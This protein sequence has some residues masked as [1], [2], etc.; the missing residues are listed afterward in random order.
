MQM[1]KVPLLMRTLLLMMICALAACSGDQAGASSASQW[2]AFDQP[3]SPPT[4]TTD[5]L[6]PLPRACDLSTL[7]Q[8]QS[9]LQQSATQMSD[10]P[11]ACVWA[12]ADSPGTITMFMVLLSELDDIATAQEV[13]NNVTGLQG[14]LSVMVNK[15]I[16][17]KTRKSGQEID[18]LGDEAWMSASNTDLVGGQQLV[19]RKGRRVLTLN[20]TGMGKTD[21]LAERMGM[22]ARTAVPKL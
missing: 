14:N 9:V 12:S 22:L 17:A 1:F 2:P 7:E 21:G 16:D 19:V 20:V 18:D 13:F 6:T 11:D 10:D 8:A 15:Q 4:E 3:D 5:T